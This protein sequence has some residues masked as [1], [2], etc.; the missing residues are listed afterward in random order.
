MAQPVK[1]IDATG[2][3]TFSPALPLAVG[4][5]T[6]AV[7][8]AGNGNF[9]ASSTTT[10]F[11]ET[12]NQDGTNIANVTAAPGSSVYGQTV[13]FSTVVTAAA[14][15]S[16]TPSGTVSF[17]DGGTLLGTGSLDGAGKASFTTN[18]ALTVGQHTITASYSGDTNFLGSATSGSITENVAQASTTTATVIGNPSTSVYGQIVTFTTTVSAV[19]PGS[20]IPSGTVTFKDGL[21][22]LGTA[23][24]DATG[25]ATFSTTGPLAIGAHSISAV[26]AGDTNF[27][28]SATASPFAELVNLDNSTISVVSSA[29]P[30][31]FGQAVTLTVTIGAA[32]PGSGTPTGTVI[33]TL[34]SNP[35]SPVALD[36]NGK[37]SLSASSLSVGTHTLKVFYVG[38]RTFKHCK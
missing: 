24:L 2:K 27:T 29:Q 16:G 35:A 18:A 25:K 17:F 38:Q 14:P 30:A 9:V 26:Y 19:L 4:T 5:H 6:V 15:G 8:Y 23:S 10:T 12:V 11:T 32:A 3:A 37:A 34:D 7:T 1:S 22:T 28:G 21:A 31:V 20:G 36:V 33:L 13:Q